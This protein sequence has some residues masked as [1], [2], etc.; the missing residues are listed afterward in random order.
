MRLEVIHEDGSKEIIDYKGDKAIVG[1]GDN[2]DI[3]IDGQYIANN[4]IIL[5]QIDGKIYVTDLDNPNGT[6]INDTLLEPHQRVEFLSFFPI[7]IGPKILIYLLPEDQAP[8]FATNE[9]AE[10]KPAPKV[11]FE[12]FKASDK[13]QKKKEVKK[14]E[15]PKPQKA[16][17]SKSKMN[18]QMITL[19]VIG[20]AASYYFFHK[21]QSEKKLIEEMNQI[22]DPYLIYQENNTKELRDK[23]TAN[24]NANK[25]DGPEEVELCKL[26]DEYLNAK[27]GIKID[28]GIIYIYI[29]FNFGMV[30]KY[31]EVIQGIKH[32]YRRDGI[33]VAF[34]TNPT[35]LK[36]MEE[37]GYTDLKFIDIETVEGKDKPTAFYEIN[38]DSFYKQVSFVDVR[39]SFYELTQNNP[40]NFEKL[41]HPLIERK[42]LE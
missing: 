3:K 20:L 36:A 7:Q 41:I 14:A 40:T 6:Y 19:G 15:A 33:I 30:N 37:K 2:T 38:I 31:R 18:V 21:N 8:A 28:Q 22:K 5:E 24:Y 9:P 4:Q 27:D 10:V 39:V 12:E 29:N 42:E 1:K 35:F 34:M 26:L 16:E 32:E 11:E 13:I 17:V 23:Y 25:C